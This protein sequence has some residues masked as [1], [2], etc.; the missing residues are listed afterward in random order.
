[1]PVRSSGVKMSYQKIREEMTAKEARE[2]TMID[3][4]VSKLAGHRLLIIA[5]VFR[6][7]NTRHECKA[8]GWSDE[9]LELALR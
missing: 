9:A 2:F 7:T 4:L 6:A 3:S 1:M 5:I 8:S